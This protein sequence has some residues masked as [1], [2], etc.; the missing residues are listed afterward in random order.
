MS[1][2]QAVF[3]VAVAMIAM[4]IVGV[5]VAAVAVIEEFRGGSAN[6]AQLIT[7]PYSAP[8]LQEDAEFDPSAFAAKFQKKRV[9]VTAV[10]AIAPNGWVPG[11]E[12]AYAVTFKTSNTDE[13]KVSVG[14]F[15]SDNG[16]IPGL[17]KG[18]VVSFEGTVV[19]VSNQPYPTFAMH[20]CRHLR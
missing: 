13:L 15:F 16:R 17:S 12:N 5:M 11:M 6:P 3:A 4:A 14:L 1:Q 19:P 10:V 9:R 2:K 18:Q 7:R 20:D 8:E